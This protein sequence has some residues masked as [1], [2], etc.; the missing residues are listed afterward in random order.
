[1]KIELFVLPE[2]T[3]ADFIDT[4][5][6]TRDEFETLHPDFVSSLELYGTD[7]DYWYDCA[8]LWDK[9]SPDLPEVSV[10][11]ALKLLRKREGRVLFM[12]ETQISGNPGGLILHGRQIYDYVAMA[13]AHE[14]A[15]RIEY[16]WF[17][18][19]RL[20]LGDCYLDD[21]I[22]PEDLYVFDTTLDWVIVFTHETDPD[23]DLT[24]ESAETRLCL[25]FG[26]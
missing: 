18:G 25:V 9:M 24:P 22:L 6:L 20:S 10:R 16:E 2:K 13:D 17:E 5:V 8:Y 11:E 15:D 3:R 1:M 19:H 4:F 21:A 14:L 23:K 7:Y 12:S 26:I